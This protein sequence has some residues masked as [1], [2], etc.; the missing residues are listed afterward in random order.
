MPELVACPVCGCRVQMAEALLGRQI[1]CVS[2]QGIFTATA[3]PVSSPPDPPA[4]NR[5]KPRP[6][7]YKGRQPSRP[8]CPC[9]QRPV[10]WTDAVCPYCGLE[11][12]PEVPPEVT[13][14]LPG[15]PPRRDCESHR[16]S[17]IS[18]MGNI[19]LVVGGLSVCMCGLGA[20]VS[21]PLGIV[22]WALA[23][24]D[25]AHMSQGT[26]DPAGREAT[27]TGRTGAILGILLGALFGACHAVWWF[28][29]W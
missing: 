4:P 16:G 9:C 1:R 15:G 22:T 21:I 10:A 19:S 11:F 17:L 2:C 24:N 20:V 28:G 6:I 7:R 14:G 29:K 27:E 12:D 3:D 25:L 5:P 8:L 26:M 13:P 18:T 23:N